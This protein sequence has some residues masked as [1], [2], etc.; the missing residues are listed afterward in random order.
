MGVVAGRRGSRWRTRFV[1][2]E[3]LGRPARFRSGGREVVWTAGDNLLHCR[4]SLLSVISSGSDHQ[5]RLDEVQ[6]SKDSTKGASQKFAPGFGKWHHAHR[7]KGAEDPLM[8]LSKHSERRKSFICKVVEEWE[9]YDNLSVM[10]Q[11]GLVP[12]Q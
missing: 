3:P 12:E 8:G 7:W 4:G 11:L 5:T 10:Q 2:G 1:R 6:H 9:A